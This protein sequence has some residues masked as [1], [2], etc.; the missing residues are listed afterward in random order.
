MTSPRISR[1]TG[2]LRRLADRMHAELDDAY[3][4][5]RACRPGIASSFGGGG[6]SVG[7]HTDPTGTTAFTNVWKG[8]PK[9]PDRRSPSETDQLYA[10]L[11]AAHDRLMQAVTAMN[12]QLD[13]CKATRTERAEANDLE[14]ANN[15]A[16]YCAI[17]VSAGLTDLHWHTGT[18]GDR[19]R[20]INTGE[21]D[22]RGEPIEVL[23]GEACRKSWERRWRSTSGVGLEGF[24]EWHTRRVHHLRSEHAA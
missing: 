9:N 16:G 4:L 3:S 5:A 21:R 23:M 17:C 15:R 8:D 6:R 13:R 12:I 24:D 1:D 11:V 18:D 2:D 22:D 7:S 14:A 19:L 20:A 10:R